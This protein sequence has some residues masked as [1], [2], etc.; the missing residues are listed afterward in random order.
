M[1]L[2]VSSNL[3]QRVWQQKSDLAD[4]FTK[5]YGVH[6]LVWYEPHD[7][8]ES[9]IAREKSIKGWKRAWKLTLIEGANPQWCDLY[10]ELG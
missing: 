3:T 4:G 2:G 6:T 10:E 8:M 5:R 1:Y 7:T 9:A